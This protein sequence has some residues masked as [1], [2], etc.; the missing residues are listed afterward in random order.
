MIQNRTNNF[1]LDWPIVLTYIVLVMFGYFNILSA[2]SGVEFSSY[3]DISK[4]FG[5]QL[6]FIGNVGTDDISVIDA[7]NDKLISYTISFDYDFDKIN[8]II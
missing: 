7:V 8:N 3:F 4:P 1:L 5:K 2:S 6:V